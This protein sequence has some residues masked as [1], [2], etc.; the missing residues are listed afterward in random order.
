MSKP[1]LY[2]AAIFGATSSIATELLRAL[3]AERSAE[4]VLIGR[5]SGRLEVLASDLRARGAKCEVKVADMLD[6][7]MDWQSILAGEDW[8]LFLIAHGSLPEQQ[9]VL[10]DSMAISREIEINF[11]SQVRIAAACASI[12]EKQQRG[13]IAA[14]GSVAGDR[15][16]QSNYLYGCTKAA[17]E[18][19]FAGLRHRFAQMPQVQVLL[20]KPGMT[21]T[22]MTAGIE[23]G[24]LF[25]S[26]SKVG[27]GAWKAIRRGKSVAYLPGWWRAVMFIIRNLPDFIFHRTKL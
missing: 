17:L 20:L 15:G 7:G 2:R 26:A 21:D 22:P 25:S 1:I 18:T 11:T 3:V 4:L 5:N 24:M 10:N 14:F 16:R 9:E 23:K 12:L 8:D 13:A 27:S 19:F 6:S